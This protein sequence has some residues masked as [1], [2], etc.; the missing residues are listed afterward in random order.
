M[1]VNT[2]IR[3]LHPE[4][5]VLDAVSL[6]SALEILYE[7]CGYTLDDDPLING[8]PTPV[9]QFHWNGRNVHPARRADHEISMPVIAFILFMVFNAAAIVKVRSRVYDYPPE[10]YYQTALGF[11][12]QAF[13]SISLSTIQAIVLL[14]VH[15]LLTPADASL[16]TLVHMAMAYCIETGIHRSSR[17]GPLED[18][19]QEQM[20]RFVFF[21]VYHLDRYNTALQLTSGTFRSLTINRSIS[22]IQGRPLGFRDETFDAKFPDVPSAEAHMQDGQSS[23][24]LSLPAALYSLNQFKLDRIVSEIK[25]HFYHLPVKSSVF[26][27]PSEP[28]RLQEDIQD[29]LVRWWDAS[30]SESYAERFDS[31]QRQIWYL[32]LNIRYHTT[33]L[34]LFQPSQVIRS[35]TENSLSTCFHSACSILDSYRA[36][37]DL[38]ALHHGWR[39]VQ[40]VFAAGATLIYSFWTSRTVQQN[41][42]TADISRNLRTCS[43]LLTVGGEW[44]PSA[45]RASGSFGLVADLTIQKLYTNVMVSKH[46]RLFITRESRWRP[47]SENRNDT[48][49]TDISESAF[50]ARTEGDSLSSRLQTH[51]AEIE[52]AFPQSGSSDWNILAE[53]ATTANPATPEDISYLAAGDEA[54]VYAPEIENFFSGFDRAEFSWGFTLGTEHHQEDADFFNP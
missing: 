48:I 38:H 22:C 37:H 42:S 16:W 35:P 32:K 54:L 9:T 53:A 23:T 19:G 30:S 40:N 29:S 46:P 14:I 18:R 24:T 26:S 5:P 39:T 45:K 47:Q 15:S 7:S 3:W 8:W 6:L 36:L 4:Y 50:F 51:C 31:R 33:R 2:Y 10:R 1:L 13:S 20:N 21:T 12:T 41:P 27:W 25:L 34:L 44:W 52:G 11:S 49:L 17:L 28:Q 43:N